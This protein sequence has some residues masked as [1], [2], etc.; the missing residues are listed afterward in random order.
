MCNLLSEFDLLSQWQD[1]PWS[2]V[3][4]EMVPMYY[5][6]YS[7]ISKKFPRS[8]FSLPLVMRLKGLEKLHQNNKE[9]STSEDARKDQ[10]EKILLSKESQLNSLMIPALL[11]RLMLLCL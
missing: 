11:P 3:G 4:E 9:K 7:P 1:S 5:Q 6:G 8:I 10:M 2:Y